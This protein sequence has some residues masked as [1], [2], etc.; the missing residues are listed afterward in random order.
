MRM[1]SR[2][3]SVLHLAFLLAIGIALS[4]R[5]TAQSASWTNGSG[6]WSDANKW[7]PS[8]SPGPGTNAFFTNNVAASYTVTNNVLNNTF[9]NLTVYRPGLAS[10]IFSATNGFNPTGNVFLGSGG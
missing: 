10:T 4:P 2:C 1:F 6:N 8:V 9:G 7:S 5:A 3:S